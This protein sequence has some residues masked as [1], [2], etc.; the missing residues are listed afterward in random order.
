MIRFVKTLNINIENIVQEYAST[1]ISANT[2]WVA[3]SGGADSTVL[4]HLMAQ[5]TQLQ[6]DKIYNVK[7]LH[8]NH[9]LSEHADNWQRHC[10]A[11]CA[12]LDI[13]CVSKKVLVENMGK[14]IESSA[15][16]R[17]Y[18]AFAQVMSQGDI[19]LC[20]HHR[21]DVAETIIYRL[22]RGAGL[23]GLTGIRSKRVFAGGTLLR[24]LLNFSRQQIIQ[25]AKQHGL[26]WIEDES[27]SD[28]YY[29]RNFLRHSL[30]PILSKRWPNF[31]QRLVT[32]SAWLLESS[33]LLS[34]Y[35]QQDLAQCKV[36]KMT[37]HEL[38][39]SL[40]L[41]TFSGFS[42]IRQK[43]LVRVWCQRLHFS[44]PDG[45]VIEQLPTLLLARNASSPVLCWGNVELRRYKKR[46]FLTRKLPSC[47]QTSLPIIWDGRE[48][49][50]LSDGSTL[51]CSYAGSEAISFT[52]KYRS[53]GER[54]QPQ[55][56]THS[57]TL[58][59]LLQEYEL[60][61]WLR[62]RVPLIYV[63]DELVAVGDIFHCKTIDNYTKTTLSFEW[64]YHFEE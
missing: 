42:Y 21:D 49:L 53:G 35:A 23:Q 46:L 16:E 48:P 26:N 57:Q 20:G 59:K 10:E 47:D 4:L 62:Q 39:E 50:K 2:L 28:Q 6:N 43:H 11:F 32:T 64:H 52:V 17:R 56:R 51:H 60:E 14:G 45:V 27:N 63:E 38:G 36:K 24:P 9:Q 1:L 55:Q 19:I 13:T 44:V 5:L 41:N 29:D 7:A 37:R 18:Q 22:M 31:Q 61:P 25:Y 54:C 3:F 58:K 15:R 34:E 12:S 30:F 8:V 33:I 40:C